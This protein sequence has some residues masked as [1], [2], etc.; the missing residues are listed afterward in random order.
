MRSPDIHDRLSVLD[1]ALTTNPVIL[2]ALRKVIADARKAYAGNTRIL[3]AVEELSQQAERGVSIRE[4]CTSR[5]RWQRALEVSPETDASLGTILERVQ[6]EIQVA[7]LDLRDW[8]TPLLPEE[9]ITHPIPRYGEAPWYL[10]SYIWNDGS[11]GITGSVQNDPHLIY[12]RTPEAFVRPGDS[13]KPAAFLEREPFRDRQIVVRMHSECLLGDSVVSQGRCDCGQQFCNAM[14]AINEEGAGALIYLRQE[15]R[16]IGLRK[17]LPALGLADGRL[18]GEWVGGAF[19]TETAMTALGHQRAD[20]RQFGFALRML[21]SLGPVGKIQLITDN[22]RKALLFSKAGY[23]V[24]LREAAGTAMTLE[25][26]MEFLVKIRRGY[27]IPWDRIMSVT[28]HIQSLKE[29]REI[30]PTL[31]KI[32]IEILDYVEQ[33]NEHTVPEPLVQL[34][35]SARANLTANGD[36]DATNA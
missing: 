12:L 9:L 23:D 25:N 14:D 17:K 8:K 2:S 10:G 21:R 33:K 18:Q 30:D 4:L 36:S 6:H 1:P 34:L 15:G 35:R 22:P 16:G 32:L 27:K 13:M 28:T 31:F 24:E 11:S 26:L 7:L 29:G 3:G 5:I 19:N 20:F